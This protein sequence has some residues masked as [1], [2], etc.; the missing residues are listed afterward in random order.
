LAITAFPTSDFRIIPDAK[1]GFGFKWLE[2]NLISSA[3]LSNQASG[4]W[5]SDEMPVLL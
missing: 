5:P 2:N 4:I 1:W 3:H